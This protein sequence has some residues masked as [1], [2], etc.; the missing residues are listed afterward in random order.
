[1]FEWTAPVWVWP[2]QH[3]SACHNHNLHIFGVSLRGLSIFLRIDHEPEDVSA[4]FKAFARNAP[5]GMIRVHDLREAL[6][7]RDSWDYWDLWHS[8]DLDWEHTSRVVG[9]WT[10]DLHACGSVRFPS[11]RT[12]AA[13][14]GHLLIHL[15]VDGPGNSI[16]IFAFQSGLAKGWFRLWVSPL[17]PCSVKECFVSSPDSNWEFFK[18]P[19]SRDFGFPI[20][21]P[22]GVSWCYRFLRHF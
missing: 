20:S 19:G 7:T 4:A 22:L 2:N 9:L 21:D 16:N 12:P 3:L 11:G 13:L 8:W 10:Q 18:P 5:D 14:Q 17:W 15:R 6:R 1:M